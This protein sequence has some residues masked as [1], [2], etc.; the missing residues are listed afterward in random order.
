MN[1][2]GRPTAGERRRA[3]HEDHGG[4]LHG[5]R[6]AVRRGGQRL[7]RADLPPGLVRPRADQYGDGGEGQGGEAADRGRRDVAAAG[8]STPEQDR[9][10]DQ[11]AQPDP[12]GQQVQHGDR[13]GQRHLDTGGGM[14]RGGP[15]ERQGQGEKRSAQADTGT[16]V[17]PR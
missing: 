17:P 12:H 9:Q 3:Q 13:N 7:P 6:P 5:E 16:E 4:D 15:G 1:E 14:F 8:P 11:T 2:A 10:R